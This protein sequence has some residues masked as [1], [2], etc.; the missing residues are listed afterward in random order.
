MARRR[1]GKATARLIRQVF[2]TIEEADITACPI[3]KA[4][5][6]RVYGLA[7]GEQVWVDE[8]ATLHSTL[9]H[10]LLHLIHPGWDEPTVEAHT[11]RVLNAMTQGQV[12]ELAA[13][14]HARKQKE[15]LP[16]KP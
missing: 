16:V 11:R 4:G 13:A 8:N 6:D 5:R 15:P 2:D 14:Y 1:I 9:V 3:A 7:Q 10:E 12:A